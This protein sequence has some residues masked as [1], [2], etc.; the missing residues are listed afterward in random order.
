MN[1]IYRKANYN[2]YAF[3]DGGYIVHNMNLPF[4][5]GHTHIRNYHTAKFLIDLSYHRSIPNK[6]LN[7]YLLESLIRI[8]DSKE[9]KNKIYRILSKTKK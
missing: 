2:I 6:R 7:K 3:S 5:K 1:R 8:S 9:Y 4:E